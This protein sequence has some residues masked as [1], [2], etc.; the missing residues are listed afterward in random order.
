MNEFKMSDEQLGMLLFKAM[1]EPRLHQKRWIRDCGGIG[2]SEE[3]DKMLAIAESRDKAVAK[4]EKLNQSRM[5][6]LQKN[7]SVAESAI[8]DL[9]SEIRQRM[10][11]SGLSQSDLATACNW[12]PSL[13]SRYLSKKQ[14]PGLRNLAKIA[15]CLGLKIKLEKI[16]E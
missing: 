4:S 7:D 16:A 11:D 12:P 1:H 10:E 3:L 6:N 15:S 13:V 14:E 5:S 2:S 8:D 9:I